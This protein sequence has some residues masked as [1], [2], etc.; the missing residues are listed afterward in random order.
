MELYVHGSVEEIM[1]VQR[2]LREEFPQ[3]DCV[4][5]VFDLGT[6]K[7]NARIHIMIKRKEKF[8]CN[9]FVMKSILF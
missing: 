6:D 8:K 5:P 1:T 9:M 7:P 3:I 4:F 2:L